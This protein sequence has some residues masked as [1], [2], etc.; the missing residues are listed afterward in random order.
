MNAV[1]IMT[2]LPKNL[3]MTNTM[4]GILSAGTRF[5]RMGKN[6][7]IKASAFILQQNK[8]GKI[9]NVLVAKMMNKAP[10]CKPILKSALGSRLPPPHCGFAFA[11]DVS[12]VS[13]AKT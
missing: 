13:L 8:K 11:S 12:E 5:E 6:A 10:I 7:P 3:A 4:F 9:P 1:A 2:P